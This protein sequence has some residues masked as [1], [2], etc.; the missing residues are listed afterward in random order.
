MVG[1]HDPTDL[2]Q[3]ERLHDSQKY[4]LLLHINLL[5][6]NFREY[7]PLS[8]SEVAPDDQSQCRNHMSNPNHG[9]LSAFSN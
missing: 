9:K 2:L 1:F 8:V 3:L 7:S 5:P 6:S 4:S